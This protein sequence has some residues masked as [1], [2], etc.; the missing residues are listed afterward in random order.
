MR[1]Y[2]TPCPSLEWEG[3]PCA[4]TWTWRHGDAWQLLSKTCDCPE[5]G[6]YWLSL[7]AA[8]EMERQPVG[9]APGR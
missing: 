7:F 8:T 9:A 5:D 6:R 3:A 2:E 4:G 1:T